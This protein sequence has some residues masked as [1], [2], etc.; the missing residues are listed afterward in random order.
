MSYVVGCGQTSA[1]HAWSHARGQP[2]HSAQWEPVGADA[3]THNRCRAS[4]HAPR[5][6]RHDP[7]MHC[8]ISLFDARYHGMAQHPA[9]PA[10]QT[11][12]KE[13][14]VTTTA[15]NGALRAPDHVSSCLAARRTLLIRYF[16]THTHFSRHGARPL[17]PGR[18]WAPQEKAGLPCTTPFPQPG[19]VRREFPNRHSPRAQ[20]VVACGSQ[21]PATKT[22]QHRKPRTG[23]NMS[24]YDRSA[25]AFGDAQLFGVCGAVPPM[26][27]T[28]PARRGHALAPC[29]TC[30][31]TSVYMAT[32]DNWL[33]AAACRQRRPRGAHTRQI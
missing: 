8:N 4:N 1:Q 32:C 20:S 26:P 2:H 19:K 28:P 21:T 18:W 27:R 14:R 30:Q 31:P 16:L 33:L 23:S 10:L 3:Q 9:F 5:E 22:I 11:C 29:A 7:V 12:H 6:R 13:R 25:I 15:P 24:K 17:P